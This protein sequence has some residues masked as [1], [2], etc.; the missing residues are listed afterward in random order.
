[1]GSLRYVTLTYEVSIEEYTIIVAVYRI[2]KKS[3]KEDKVE[4]GLGEGWLMSDGLMC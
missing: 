1:M 2:L 4:N 3:K